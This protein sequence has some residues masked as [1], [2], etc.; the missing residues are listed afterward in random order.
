[1]KYCS[2]FDICF[3][4]NLKNGL[5]LYAF[6]ANCGEKAQLAYLIKHKKKSIRIN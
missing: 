5:G 1:M 3:G 4:G 6:C 2:P